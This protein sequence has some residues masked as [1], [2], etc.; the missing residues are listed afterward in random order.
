M[1]K[2]IIKI[3]KRVNNKKV[4]NKKGGMRKE[5]HHNNKKN[6]YIHLHILIHKIIL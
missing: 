2:C 3:K 1:I 6:I 5:L 4:L